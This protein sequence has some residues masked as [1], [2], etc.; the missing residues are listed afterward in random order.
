[1]EI[2]DLQIMRGPNYWSNYRQKLVV[3]KLDIGALEHRPSN[4]IPGFA[5]RLADCLPSLHSH[6]CSYGHEGGFLRRV[7]EGTWMGHIVEHVALELQC[8]AG[9]ECGFGRTR[10][11]RTEGVYHVVFSYEVEEAGT[12]AAK[13]AVHLV[14]AL[15][16]GE[17]LDPGPCVEE[18]TRINREYG[19]G[20]STASIVAEAEKRNI[21]Y[22]R[23]GN[24][25]L[26]VFGQGVHQKRIRATMTGTTSCL[27]V[28]LAGEKDETKNLLRRAYIPVPQGGTATDPKELMDI[29]EKIGYPV[30]VKPVDGNHGRG[31]STDIRTEAEALEALRLAQAVSHTVVVERF[32]EGFDYRFLVINHKLVAVA[33]RTPASVT[34]DGRS[35]VAELIEEVNRQPERGEGHEK[36]LTKITLD[37]I[38]ENLLRAKNLTPDS[39]LPENE[40]LYLKDSANLSAGGISADVTDMVHPHNVAMAERISHLLGLDICGIDVVAQNINIPIREEV[41]GVVE[42]NACPG[43]RMHLNPVGGMAR[44]VAKPVMGMLY[45][46]GAPCRIPPVAGTGTNG[47]TTTTRLLAHIAK[48]AGYRVGYT[49]TDGIYL[50]DRLIYEGDCSGPQS[51]AMVLGE[52]TIDFAVLECARGGILRSGLGFDHCNVSIITNVSDDHLGLNDIHTPEEMARVKEVVAQSTFNDGYC[53]LNADD[54]LVYAMK[55]RLDCRV[56]LFSMNSNSRRVLDHLEMAG[57]ACVVEDGYLTVYDGDEQ[58]R[59]SKIDRIPLSLGGKAGCMVQNLMAATLA[60]IVQKIPLTRLRRALDTFIPSPGQTPGRCNFFRF[61]SFDGVG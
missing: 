31:V 19:F 38:T 10:S 58:L 26:V 51:A 4:Q 7:E 27:G 54:D 57:L 17:T 28:E 16:R 11:T 45:P 35:S 33:R 3:M 42:V 8:L 46:P 13:A 5:R 20:P 36:T 22:R 14:H 12:Y 41:G 47:K 55:E 30:V 40:T 21:P 23:I 32:L 56:A 18:L 52:P 53:I 6:R 39:V 48:E 25:S 9:M 1:M 29:I 37:A 24:D 34:G 2:L 59:I 49:S 15:T 50:H 44:N 60:A 61:L 43:F